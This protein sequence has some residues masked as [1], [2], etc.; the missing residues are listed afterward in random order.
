MGQQNS[1]IFIETTNYNYQIWGVQDTTQHI[2]EML[3]VILPKYY[4][5]H[6]LFE[7]SAVNQYAKNKK[8]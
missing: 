7:I 4:L 8:K 2:L 3:Q 5:G 1:T 6:I